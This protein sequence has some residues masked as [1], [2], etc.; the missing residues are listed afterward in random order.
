MRLLLAVEVTARGLRRLLLL[1][2]QLA[3]VVVGVWLLAGPVP[4]V[5]LA[6]VL[7]WTLWTL[8]RLGRAR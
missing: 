7:V 4:A 6:A 2:G 5:V 3:A 8:A 1:T